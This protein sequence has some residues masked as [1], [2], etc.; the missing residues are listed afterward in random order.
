MEPRA[1]KQALRRSMVERILALD[2]VERRRQEGLLR[3]QAPALPGFSGAATVLLYAP[4]FPEEIDTRPL[5][6][7]ALASGKRLALPRVDRRAKRLRLYLIDDVDRDLVPGT[8]NIPEPRPDRPE[9][10][11]AEVDW[12]LVP[13]LAFDARGFRLGRGAGHYDRLLPTLRADA[14]RWALALTPQ[15]VEA[16]PV[17]PHDQPLDGLL[18]PDRRVVSPS[19]RISWQVVDKVDGDAIF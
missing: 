3:E 10:S 6:I 9:L 19:G 4:A 14:P 11:P 15:L 2:P 7:A 5:L 1:V 16:L 17:E 13:G 18:T 8:L 12:A